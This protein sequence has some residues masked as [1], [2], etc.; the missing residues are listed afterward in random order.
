MSQVFTQNLHISGFCSSC[1]PTMVSRQGMPG[2]APASWHCDICSDCG[3]G[4]APSVG[5]TSLDFILSQ[6]RMLDLYIVNFYWEIRMGR[7]STIGWIRW[8]SECFGD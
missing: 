5:S 2:W 8:L 1:G 6:V 4:I 3:P 7:L